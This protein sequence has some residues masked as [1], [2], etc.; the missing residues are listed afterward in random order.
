MG[1]PDLWDTSL[2]L[3]R[4]LQPSAIT[5]MEPGPN[6][7]EPRRMFPQPT[8]NLD[9]R[10]IKP[11]LQSDDAPANLYQAHQHPFSTLEE[12]GRGYL[13]PRRIVLSQ[14]GRANGRS[15]CWSASF[16]TC[17]PPSKEV[18]GE[19]AKAKTGGDTAN[20]ER[21]WHSRVI[22]QIDKYQVSTRKTEKSSWQ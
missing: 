17:L 6:P 3:P 12:V 19:D 5:L 8:A 13:I 4:T 18:Q 14:F 7:C 22:T 20:K 16:S 1:S 2:N 11:P 9:R 21:P 10:W 15:T